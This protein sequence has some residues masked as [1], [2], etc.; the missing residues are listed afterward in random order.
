MSGRGDRDLGKERFWRQV[1]HRWQQSGRT[2]RDFCTAH[3]LSEQ[4]FYSWRRT[5]AAR[6]HEGAAGQPPR[7][8]ATRSKANQ[9]R[10]VFVPVRVVGA[11][12]ALEVVLGDGRVVR[13]PTGFDAVALR[14]LL[15]VLEEARPC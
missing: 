14:Q 12:A 13:V 5:I 6:D 10:A 1:L 4:S 7:R 8:R 15:A 11:A 2:V 3:R 9:R